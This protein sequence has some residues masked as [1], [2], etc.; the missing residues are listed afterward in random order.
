M[1]DCHYPLMLA[2][3]M[4]VP[5]M[6]FA[7]VRYRAPRE[8]DTENGTGALVISE[9]VHL[10]ERVGRRM[11]RCEACLPPCQTKQECGGR[12]K[13]ENRTETACLG[14]SGTSIGCC[15]F[16]LDIAN[17]NSSNRIDCRWERPATI[18]ATST[19][20]QTCAARRRGCLP[21]ASC[22]RKWHASM[23]CSALGRCPNCDKR[24]NT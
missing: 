4:T 8:G 17:I 13:G 15:C 2:P 18:D 23:P 5:I 3:V 16:Q 10:K 7:A 12:I 11:E 21:L 20:Q 19:R 22:T 14:V 1:G 6:E 9:C 24:G